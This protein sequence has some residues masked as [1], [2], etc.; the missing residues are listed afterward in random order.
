LLDGSFSGC[1]D[2]SPGWNEIAQNPEDTDP[3]KRRSGLTLRLVVERYVAIGW[4]RHRV[5]EKLVNLEACREARH[6]VVEMKR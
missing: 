5:R 4:T 3:V 6:F 2:T 1:E